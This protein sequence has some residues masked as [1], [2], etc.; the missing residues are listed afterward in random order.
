MIKSTN[1][2][3]QSH[4]TISLAVVAMGYANTKLL[5]RFGCETSDVT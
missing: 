2:W 4:P 1:G 5:V 3:S